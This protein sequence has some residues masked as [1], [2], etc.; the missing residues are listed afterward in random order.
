VAKDTMKILFVNGPFD[1]TFADVPISKIRH[2]VT[3]SDDDG[4]EYDYVFVKLEDFE[5]GEHPMYVY[6]Q[7]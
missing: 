7:P 6:K 5:H 1:D 2:T 4:V 3:V